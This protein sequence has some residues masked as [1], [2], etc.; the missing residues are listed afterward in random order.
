[1]LKR[2]YIHNFRAFVNFEWRPPRASVLVGENGAGKS[3]L[4]EVLWLL[5]DLVVTGKTIDETVSNSA[6]TEWLK[7]EEQ[8]VEIELEQEG[9]VSQYRLG[10]RARAIHE[11]LR[12]GGVLLYKAADG[13]VEL[14]G[15]NPSPDG[16]PRTTI[17]FD[18]RRSFLSALEPRA[19]NTRVTAFRDQISSIWAMK[20]DP[21]RLGGAAVA[22]SAFLDRD[23]SNFANWYRDKAPEDPDA[24]GLLREDLQRPFRDPALAAGCNRRGG[25]RR[26]AAAG[27]LAPP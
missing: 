11:E 20:P 15:N 14:H 19:D 8:T 7:D 12:G 3:A 22:E 24:A 10:I 25:R 23:L 2:I 18:R 26:Q 6:R 17:P 5:Q 27:G 21:R 16:T 4:I 13:R 1:M 9:E